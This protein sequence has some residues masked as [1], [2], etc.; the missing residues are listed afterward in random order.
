MSVENVGDL[1]EKKLIAADTP[2]TLESLMYETK[3]DITGDIR[4]D[5]Y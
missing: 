2:S 5:Q 1:R 4:F 3:G